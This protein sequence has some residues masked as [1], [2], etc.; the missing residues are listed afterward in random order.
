MERTLA[1]LKPDIMARHLEKE[2]IQTLEKEGFK[3]LATQNI[4]MNK[5]QAE[6]F[7]KS[8]KEKDFFKELIQYMT[9]YDSLL[10]VLEKEN[11]IEDLRN[12]IGPTQPEKG[13]PKKHLRARFGESTTR[14][15]I[16]ASDSYENALREIECFFPALS[17]FEH[18]E[19]KEYLKAG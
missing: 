10:M 9:S 6:Y 4:S 15:S 13:D 7:Y 19:H 1:I 18:D 8:H 16:H 14:N 17:Y 12:L 3:I 11:A 2:V 5:W